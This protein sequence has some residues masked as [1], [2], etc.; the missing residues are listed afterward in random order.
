M[1]SCVGSLKRYF[2]DLRSV[3]VLMCG[4]LCVVLF[5]LAELGI[6]ANTTF[7]A[8]GPRPEL[9]FMHMSIDTYYKYDL[10]IVLIVV[11]TFITDIIADSLSPHVVNVVQVFASHCP[12]LCINHSLDH[13]LH[14]S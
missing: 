3:S 8:F 9:K 1:R 7:V 14:C 12:L 6:F 2:V 11:H 13:C 4:W 10:L 5:I